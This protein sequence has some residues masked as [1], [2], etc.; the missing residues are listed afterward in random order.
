MDE[1][2]FA[3]P[4][5]IRRLTAYGRDG[6]RIGPVGDVYVNDMGRGPEWV[7]VRTDEDDSGGDILARPEGDIFA[8]LDGAAHTREGVLDLAFTAEAVRSAPRMDSEQHLGIV[9][10]QELFLHYG[11]AIPAHEASGAPGVGDQRPKWPVVAGEADLRDVKELAEEPPARTARLRRYVP[12]ESVAE[13]QP[14]PDPSPYF[15]GDRG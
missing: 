15:G 12:G 3:D 5:A 2:V 9:Q 11:L 8:P 10:E 1:D 4:E 13:P 7:T 14:D 6:T